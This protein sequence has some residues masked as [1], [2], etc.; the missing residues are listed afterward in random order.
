MPCSI[1]TSE[2]AKSRKIAETYKGAKRIYYIYSGTVLIKGTDHQ[3][4][5]HVLVKQREALGE[6]LTV[7]CAKPQHRMCRCV[8]Q[9]TN[10]E[11]AP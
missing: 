7:Y 3:R 8:Y 4:T 1:R 10:Q 11:G 9:T 5:A 6:L 2:L